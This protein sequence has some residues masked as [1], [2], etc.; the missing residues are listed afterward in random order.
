M[1]MKDPVAMTM[2][3][4]DADTFQRATTVVPR[5]AKLDGAMTSDEGLALRIDGEFKGKLD[6]RHEGAVHI[7]EGAN[8]E[9]ESLTADYIYVQGRIKGSLVARKGLELAASAR[10]SGNVRYETELDVHPGA[11]I[12]G[13]IT[14]PEGDE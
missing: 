5:G 3:M 9:C 1:N 2:R 7:G 13:T 6:I 4:I 11:R 10:V 8:M 14:G 12:S